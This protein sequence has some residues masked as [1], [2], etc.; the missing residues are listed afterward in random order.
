M[1]LEDYL[2]EFLFDC[3]IEIYLNVQLKVTRII[4]LYL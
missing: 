1:L 2:K 4:M 3:Q